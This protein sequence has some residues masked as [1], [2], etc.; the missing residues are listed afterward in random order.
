VLIWVAVLLFTILPAASQL[1][2]WAG[3]RI[4]RN[5][6][7]HARSH[8]ITLE[9]GVLGLAGLLIGFTF[10]MASDRYEQRKQIT[11]NSSNSIGTT[12][13]RTRMLDPA[14]GDELRAMLRR[15]VDARLAFENAGVDRARVEEILRAADSL[16][17][18]IWSRVAAFGRSQPQSQVTN[19]IVQSTNEMI[20]RAAEHT[21]A[22]ENPVPF[23][24]FVL[25]VVVTTVA[26]ASIGLSC[27]LGGSRMAF[28]MLLM[29]LML[30][31]VLTMVIDLAHPRIGIVRVRDDS[32]TRLKQSF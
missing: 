9:A 28:G 21:F 13:L 17:N 30:A 8:V 15:Y 5:Q 6:T 29:P 26:M 27:G 2:Y 22:L 25:L 24:V 18:Q 7:E 32:L 4:A 23:T 3:R 20:D 19:L 10:S 31:A 16:E 12:Y 14:T 1:G 11:I